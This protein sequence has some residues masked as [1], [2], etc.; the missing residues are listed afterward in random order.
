MSDSIPRARPPL[1]IDV[2]LLPQDLTPDQTHNK[3]VVVFDVLRATT[4]ITAAL[5]AGVHEIR[6][7]PDIH[8]AAQAAT[9]FPGPRIVA[10]EVD[11]LPPP[12]FDLGNS[13][14][15]FTPERHA[16]RTAFLSTTNGTKAVIAARSAAALLIGALVNASAVAQK[17]AQI[18]R[19]ATLLCAGTRGQPAMEDLLGAGAVI[20]ALMTAGAGIPAT[21][22]AR[23]AL[24]LFRASKSSL[25][26]TM[27]D[28][29][30][31]RHVLAVGL[32]A[33]IDCCAALDSIPIVGRVLENPLRV[34][35]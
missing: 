16:G 30:G 4:T 27:S 19:S 31:G 6:I 5:A 8:S 25:R 9:Q 13:P 32:G 12:G 17:I 15:A 11:C 24:K 23:I 35:K 3:T 22:T 34:I 28:A 29:T 20:D 26:Q 18:G 7:F 33:D 21:D 2:A 14:G 10:G 1:S